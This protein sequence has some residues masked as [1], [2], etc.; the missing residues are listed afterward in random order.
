M[1]YYYIIMYK[2]QYDNKIKKIFI[3]LTYNFI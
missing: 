1:L 3:L 2:S